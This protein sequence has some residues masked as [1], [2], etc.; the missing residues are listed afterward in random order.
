VG[1]G[2]GRRPKNKMFMGA[3]FGE[4]S[5]GG[6]GTFCSI[7][8]GGWVQKSNINGTA[9]GPWGDGVVFDVGAGR[10]VT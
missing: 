5:H 9:L 1:G 3:R 2:F 7:G 10:M 6:G 8:P 4:A